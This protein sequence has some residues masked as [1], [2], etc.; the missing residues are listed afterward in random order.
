MSATATTYLTQ[1][2]QGAKAASFTLAS[3]TSK[4]KSQQEASAL[5]C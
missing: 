5:R 1:L 4:Q 3:L 2:G